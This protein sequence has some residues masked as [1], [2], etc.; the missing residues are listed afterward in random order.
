[1][2]ILSL[3]SAL[4]V[5]LCFGG[6]YRIMVQNVCMG[7]VGCYMGIIIFLMIFKYTII[8]IYQIIVCVYG[9]HYLLFCTCMVDMLILCL[10][11]VFIGKVEVAPIFISIFGHKAGIMC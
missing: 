6:I 2:M 7:L 8:F 11:N 10:F 9:I 3:E 4:S 5:N 1:M